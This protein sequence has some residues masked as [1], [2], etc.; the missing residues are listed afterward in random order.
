MLFFFFENVRNIVKE[1][2]TAATI[3]L[4]MQHEIISKKIFRRFE[5][6]ELMSDESVRDG[7]NISFIIISIVFRLKHL[8]RK[9]PSTTAKHSVPD[10]SSV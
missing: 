5:D 2:E 10:L 7:V 8:I 1:N 9:I 4:L 3:Y 6:L